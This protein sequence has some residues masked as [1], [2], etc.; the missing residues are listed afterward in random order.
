VGGDPPLDGAEIGLHHLAVAG[1]G[2]E[3]GD[4]EPMREEAEDGRETRAS[5]RDLH[6]Q[7]RAA[8]GAPESERLLD[9]RRRIDRDGRVDLDGGEA[10]GAVRALVDLGSTGSSRTIR[11][12]RRVAAREGLRR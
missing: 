1:A 6:H 8:D 7:I 10:V 3:K 12:L 11:R 4:V 2:E 5:G 9:L